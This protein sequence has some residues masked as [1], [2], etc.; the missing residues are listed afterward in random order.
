M[1]AIKS[2]PFSR[3]G[4]QLRVSLELRIAWLH[5][6]LSTNH[7]TGSVN[8][9]APGSEDTEL[10]VFMGLEVGHGQADV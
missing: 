7:A 4:M 3:L 6:L 1:S 8:W 9:P 5:S 10:G 2:F